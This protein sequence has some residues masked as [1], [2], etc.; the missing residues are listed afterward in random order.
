M[1]RNHSTA[2]DNSA[3]S[4][5]NHPRIQCRIPTR[6]WGLR[7]IGNGPCGNAA[8]GSSSHVA[9]AATPVSRERGRGGTSLNTSRAAVN[10]GA[11]PAPRPAS[12]H[13]ASSFPGRI[14]GP[15][16]T[17]PR[18]TIGRTVRPRTSVLHDRTHAAGLA[19]NDA[20]PPCATAMTETPRCASARLA[21]IPPGRRTAGL[22]PAMDS[23]ASDAAPDSA[24]R[25]AGESASRPHRLPPQRFR[26]QGPSNGRAS[27]R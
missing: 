5:T 6:D 25:T 17:M 10:G 24:L 8:P 19:L 27:R 1:W 12:H 26:A 16:G 13:I 9:G 21:S 18:Q 3:A 15:E 11:S 23:G 14:T 20:E 2:A 7:T 22:S 4:R